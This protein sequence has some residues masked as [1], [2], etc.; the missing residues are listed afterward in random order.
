MSHDD[1]YKGTSKTSFA[2]A[3]KEA[4]RHAEEGNHE[5]KDEQKYE[6]TLYV[7]GVKGNSLSEYIVIATPRD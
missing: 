7:K 3:A 5:L 4:V 6:I 1:G 2:E